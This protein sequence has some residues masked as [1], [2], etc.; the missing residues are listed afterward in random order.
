[1]LVVTQAGWPAALKVGENIAHILDAVRRLNVG[2]SVPRAI[3]GWLPT[4]DSGCHFD[5][6]R[7][8]PVWELRSC[9]YSICI[10]FIKARCG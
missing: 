7:R 3:C 5:T 8:A 9:P 6:S 1:M 2:I 10:C 4:L